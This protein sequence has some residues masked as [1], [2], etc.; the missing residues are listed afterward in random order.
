M[1]PA[2]LR[3]V[4]RTPHPQAQTT[5]PPWRAGEARKSRASAAVDALGT[6]E[7]VDSSPANSAILRKVETPVPQEGPGFRRSV[8]ASSGSCGP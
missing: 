2:P 8:T 3:A 1:T 7:A 5:A 6:Q 4:R